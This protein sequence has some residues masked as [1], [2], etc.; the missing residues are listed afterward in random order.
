MTD[1]SFLLVIRPAEEGGY[2]A[3]FPSVS[4][5]YVQ[6]ETVGELLGR[7]PSLLR[8][9]LDALD[10]WEAE[11]PEPDHQVILTFIDP[12]EGTHSAG[13]KTALPIEERHG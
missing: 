3:E 2:W 1:Q 11:R 6:G 13:E 5:C 7:A 4:G 8:S 10:Y 9:H 12:L